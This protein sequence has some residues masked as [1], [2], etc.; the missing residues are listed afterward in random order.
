MTMRNVY[1]DISNRKAG[2]ISNKYMNATISIHSFNQVIYLREI[3]QTIEC[4][5][6]LM[7]K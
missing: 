4:V 1:K 7:M 2:V 3:F 6:I 5:T